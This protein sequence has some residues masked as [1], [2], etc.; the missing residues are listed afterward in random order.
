MLQFE[1]MG[2]YRQFKII[3]RINFAQNYNFSHIRVESILLTLIPFFYKCV[4]MEE[5]QHC[6]CQRT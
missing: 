4:A 6:K 1:E 2:K 5:W 3:Y